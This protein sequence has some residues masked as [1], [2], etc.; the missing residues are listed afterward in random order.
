MNSTRKT[1]GIYKRGEIWWITFQDLS[2]RQRRETTG[3]SNKRLAERLLAVR[4]AEVVEQRL[5]LPRSHSPRLKAWAKDFLLQIPHSNTR[6]RYSASVNNLVEFFGDIR[7]ADITR[8]ALHRFQRTRVGSGIRAATVNRDRSVLSRMLNMAKKLRYISSN[9]CQDVDP[10]EERRDR[11]TAKPLTFDEEERL[12]AACDPMLA[13][14]IT[15]VAETGLRPKKEALV[16]RW[17]D[18]E[19]DDPPSIF[20]RQSKTRAGV[21]QVP[22]T[23]KCVEE[24]KQWKSGRGP[25][26]SEFVF[27]APSNP[28]RNWP[29]YQDSWKRAAKLAGLLDR[30]FYDLR[31]TFA[32]RA[33][34]E[35]P[36]DLAISRLLGHASCEILSTYAKGTDENSR[37]IISRLDLLRKSKSICKVTQ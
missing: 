20:V 12:I 32:T 16:L 5:G 1:P 11:R 37:F 21:R 2:G 10:L 31:S 17:A 34:A 7:L 4:K 15:L 29:G 6:D 9:P 30:R 18:V 13:L 14:L 28:K 8:E 23:P 27:P 26:Y 36:N 22:L 24:L 33:H 19:L 3:S 35:Y 25:A